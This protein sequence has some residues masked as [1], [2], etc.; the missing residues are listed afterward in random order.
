MSRLPLSLAARL[1]LSHGVLVAILLLLLIVTL[2]GV[3]RMVGLITE[4]SEQRLS[5]LHSEEQLHRAG[6]AVELA[7]RRAETQ[8]ADPSA[9]ASV[10]EAL[11][12]ASAKL[13]RALEQHGKAAPAQMIAAVQ[14]YRTLADTGLRG[15]TCAYFRSPQTDALRLSLD[16]ELTDVWIDRLYQL[17]SEIQVREEAARGIGVST[18]LVG[19]AIAALAA[20]AAVMIART[21]ARS[22]TDPIAR[23]AV[24][25]TRLGKGDFAPIPP[26]E[27][28][29]EIEALW[30]DL[31]RMR[32]ALLKTDQLKR[33]LP[34][35]CLA[36]AALAAGPPE[37]GHRPAHRRHD[38][39]SQRVAGAR[40]RAGAA[41]LRERGAHRDAASRHV[42][43]P[44]GP[45]DREPAG[46][47]ARSAAAHRPVG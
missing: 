27:G 8:C 20:V 15:S 47:R 29:R 28:P 31:E 9:E 35:Q 13:G 24:E 41:G 7:A 6:W 42:A 1:G 36:R 25:A 5:S 37:R 21:H 12:A 10:R 43:P 16:E 17:H 2:Q 18:L 26:V 3:F 23:L 44:V 38:R 19:L 40:R 32:T 34:G 45:A 11:T 33:A 39:G 4:I 46:L 14:G 22:L 30:R